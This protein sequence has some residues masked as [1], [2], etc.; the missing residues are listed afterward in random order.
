MLLFPILK[1][2]S[3]F[4]LPSMLQCTLCC[5][6]C[7][8]SLTH[9]PSLS[10]LPSQN[11][12]LDET[13]DLHYLKSPPTQSLLTNTH[14]DIII[15]STIYSPFTD[16]KHTH[17]SDISCV[18]SLSAFLLRSSW[19]SWHFMPSWITLNNKQFLLLHM[20]Q[21]NMFLIS[22]YLVPLPSL[23]HATLPLVSSPQ[24]AILPLTTIPLASTP[25]HVTLP[26]GVAVIGRMVRRN[27]VLVTHNI[28][29]YCCNPALLSSIKHIWM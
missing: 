21:W 5:L 29:Y 1:C 25:L 23:L 12:I 26:I 19:Y 11:L 24:P 2:L 14:P 28:N 6:S 7:C 3:C 18:S 17:T 27:I 10:E 8:Y 13:L 20:G 4:P 16:H 22:C 9:I 15:S